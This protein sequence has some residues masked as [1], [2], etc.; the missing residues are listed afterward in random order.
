MESRESEFAI[1]YE[2]DCG[3]N[4]DGLVTLT[5]GEDELYL[6]VYSEDINRANQAYEISLIATIDEKELSKQG[7]SWTLT[8]NY[9]CS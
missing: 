5:E 6:T 7:T 2:L 8:V 9:D 1:S 3:E 4:L